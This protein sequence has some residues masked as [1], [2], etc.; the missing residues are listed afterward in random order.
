LPR[1]EI[2]VTTKLW[3]LN[4]GYE[5]TIKA[6]NNSL[7]KL[8]LDYIDLYLIH[9][10]VEG[11]R[12]K[13]WKAM[14][15]LL[16]EG[17]VRAIGI[18]NYMP[19]H[20]NELLD[21]CNIK[22]VVNQIELSPYNFLYRTDIVELCQ[23][24][25]IILE[26]YSPLTKARKLQDPKLMD[27]ADKYSKT[28][29]QVLIRYIL[30]KNCVVLPKSINPSRIRENAEVFDFVISQEDIGQLDSFNE[31]LITGWDPTNAP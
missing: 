7:K 25:D 30:Q 27:I 12:L 1:E 26:A 13:S 16:E 11:L 8:G 18:S 2:F 24:N 20:L 31:N 28:P 29:A 14:E 17:E 23:T 22:P 6:C 9:W 19:S 15:F 21:N 3:N 5:Q 4:H 10:P